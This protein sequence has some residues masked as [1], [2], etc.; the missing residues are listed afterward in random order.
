MWGELRRY[1]KADLDEHDGTY[2][3]WVR[4]GLRTRR[5]LAF[6]VEAPSRTVAGSGCL[7]LMPS[8]PRPG[9]LGR[10]E[11]PYILSMY[12]EP[13]FRHRGV[14]SMIVKAMVDWSRQRGFA[15]VL[16]HASRFGRP[17]YAR[18]GF[19]PSSEMRLELVPQPPPAG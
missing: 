6:V 17:L 1:P 13:E 12:S 18:L 2:A 19:E 14:A 8:Q 3:R 4:R 9:A 10:G 5:F 15:R 16:L 7:W 11:I